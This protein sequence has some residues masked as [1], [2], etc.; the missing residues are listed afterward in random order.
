MSHKNV[1]LVPQAKPLSLLRLLLTIELA[2]AQVHIDHLRRRIDLLLR[3]NLA[4]LV[5]VGKA[6][7]EG[8]GEAYDCGGTEIEREPIP[9][10]AAG[11]QQQRI[12]QA[13]TYQISLQEVL[14]AEEHGLGVHAC[15]VG[16]QRGTFQASAQLERLQD[17]GRGGGVGLGFTSSQP[18]TSA[19]LEV[20]VHRRGLRRVLAVVRALVGVAQHD[21]VVLERGHDANAW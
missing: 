19:G 6:A 7:V 14:Q 15:A 20:A 17:G 1:L 13:T 18:H 3:H 12:I 4:D 16:G 10:L 21:D 2:G 11:P 9:L 5:C 8:S